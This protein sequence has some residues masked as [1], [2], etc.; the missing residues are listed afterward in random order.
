M[1]EEFRKSRWNQE[2]ETIWLELNR[3]GRL[4]TQERWYLG[5]Y[6]EL[7]NSTWKQ[8]LKDLT[9]RNRFLT[10]R[11][12]RLD[13]WLHQKCRMLQRTSSGK[14]ISWGRRPRRRKTL[15][16]KHWI[17]KCRMIRPKLLPT[18]TERW[19]YRCRRTRWKFWWWGKYWWKCRWQTHTWTWE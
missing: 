8:K 9:V 11:G 3:L 6:W 17:R 7:T 14:I 10:E 18:E 19:C 16:K 12:R 4:P 5:T 13:N 2:G 15:E 1:K